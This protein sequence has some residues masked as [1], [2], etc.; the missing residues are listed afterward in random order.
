M[1]LIQASCHARTRDTYDNK[2]NPPEL[3]L[4]DKLHAVS[5]LGANGWL[6]SLHVG[7]AKLLQL[8]VEVV[9]VGYGKRE[10]GSIVLGHLDINENKYTETE[11]GS[12]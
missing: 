9:V 4:H 7:D 8:V 2:I 3:L 10:V 5:I 12:H 1:T 11:P 6:V